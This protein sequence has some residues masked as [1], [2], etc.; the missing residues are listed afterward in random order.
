MVQNPPPPPLYRCHEFSLCGSLRS[1]PEGTLTWVLT[2][3]RTSLPIYPVPETDYLHRCF[4]LTLIY[5]SCSPHNLTAKSCFAMLTFPSVFPVF[6]YPLPTWTVYP[7]MK[8]LCLPKLTLP[9]LLICYIVCLPPALIFSL[10]T[11][12]D[13]VLPTWY[14][15]PVIDIC[16]SDLPCEVIKLQMDPN[17]TAS[18]LQKDFAADRSSGVLPLHHWGICSSVNLNNSSTTT[19]SPYLVDRGDVKRITGS[20]SADARSPIHFFQHTSYSPDST[21]IHH[22]SSA[23]VPWQV[24]RLPREV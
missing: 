3:I 4:S 22:Q 2:F 16:L 11:V 18:S 7:L 1:P 15:T 9:A 14:L 13:S 23:G 8:E 17:D 19:Y 21:N 12:Y 5:L 24:W 20:S 10:N 6:D